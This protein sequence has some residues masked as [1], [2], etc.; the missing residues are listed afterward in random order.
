MKG[1]RQGTGDL[2]DKTML[3]TGA[4]GGI[5]FE[6]ARALAARGARVLLGARDAARGGPAVA[7]LQHHGGRVELFAADMGSFDSVRR[8]CGR[9]LAA[10]ERL[11]VL[12]H[13]AGVATRERRVT[14]DGHELI[15]ETNFLSPFLMTR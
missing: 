14:A 4:A 3:V 5:G 15:W 1:P 8:A 2:S 7:R 9:L 10:G 6:T 11:D 13:N 12:V